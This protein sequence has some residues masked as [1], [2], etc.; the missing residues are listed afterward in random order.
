MYAEMIVCYKDQMF[1]KKV[2]PARLTMEY[3]R[4]DGAV[5]RVGDCVGSPV[6]NIDDAEAYVVMLMPGIEIVGSE[7]HVDRCSAMLYDEMTDDHFIVPVH[8]VKV[9]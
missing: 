3:T 5:I 6:V 4:D 2:R 1:P 9:K 8:L 7:V